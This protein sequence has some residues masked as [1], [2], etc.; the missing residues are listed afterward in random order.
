MSS[1]KRTGRLKLLQ[2]ALPRGGPLDTGDLAA[3]GIYPELAYRYVKSGWLERLGRGMFMFAGDQLQRDP[4]LEFLGRRI[5]GFHVGGKTA[6]AWIGLR[7]HVAFKET[8]CLWGAQQ[9]RL[10]PW[11]TER[12]PSRYTV[13]RLFDSRLDVGFALNP[14]PELPD[15]VRVSDPERGLLEMLSEVGVHQ[16]IEEARNIMELA[17]SLRMDVLRPLLDCCRQ[18]KAVRLC[19]SW[20]KELGL[21]W[22]DEA[23]KSVA[24]RIGNSR[25]VSKTKEGRTLILKPQ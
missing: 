14:L 11:F 5:P 13:R 3:L 6:L 18:I 16:G 17:S 22:A 12:F 7:H 20:S 4:C 10:P 15:G 23:A 1:S 9:T 19:V 24:A 8:L 25:W 21:P 2:T